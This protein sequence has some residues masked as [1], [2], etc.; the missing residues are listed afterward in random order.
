MIHDNIINIK[1]Y[2]DF[3]PIDIIHQIFDDK[4]TYDEVELK[5]DKRKQ[6][7]IH[8]KNKDLFICRGNTIRY[9]YTHNLDGEYLTEYDEEKDIQKYDTNDYNE[10][11]VK[12]N[13][14]LIIDENIPHKPN[15]VFQDKTSNVKVFKIE[16]NK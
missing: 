6:F 7:E 9:L 12:E 16:I 13:E 1:K 4:Y 14:F 5:E 3:I 15:T 11:L 10:I 8:R 2:K